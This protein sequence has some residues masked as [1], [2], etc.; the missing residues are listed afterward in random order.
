MPNLEQLLKPKTARSLGKMR[1]ELAVEEK[2]LDQAG[3]DPAVAE[4]L[5]EIRAAG[6]KQVKG[7]GSPRMIAQRGA[8]NRQ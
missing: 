7:N 2:L 8:N 4:V 6:K 3:G 5:R 1:A